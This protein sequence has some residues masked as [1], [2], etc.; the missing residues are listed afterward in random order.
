MRIWYKR[1]FFWFYINSWSSGKVYADCPP[2][3]LPVLLVNLR[4]NIH[5]SCSNAVILSKSV[6]LLGLF[7]KNWDE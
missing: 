7:I 4:N 1:Y 2:Y 6:R 3:L 5:L